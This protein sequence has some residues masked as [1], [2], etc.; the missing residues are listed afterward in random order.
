MGD[1]PK[2]FVSP[3]PIEFF[4]DKNVGQ[5]GAGRNFSLFLLVSGELFSVGDNRYGAC[6]LGKIDKFIFRPEKV[7][8]LPPLVSIACGIHH[9]LV[10]GSDGV[11]LGFGLSNYAQCGNGESKNCFH[12]VPL[13]GKVSRRKVLQV[14]CGQFVSA[15]ICEQHNLWT[16][17]WQKDSML[18]YVRE[19]GSF[20]NLF[21]PNSLYSGKKSEKT[22]FQRE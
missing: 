6:G 7:S 9:S 19:K 14:I 12:P 3:V 18:G 15:V 5:V 2:F 21:V 13:K 10:L 4:L 8:N 22:V 1:S 20:H 11:A 17:G 16:F